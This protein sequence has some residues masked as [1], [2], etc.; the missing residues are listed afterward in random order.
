MSSIPKVIESV[1][2][3]DLCIG[4]GICVSKCPE[5]AL[6]MDWSQD[7]FWVPKLDGTCNNDELCVSVCPFNPN[8][9]SELRTENEIANVFQKNTVL[10]HAKIGKYNGIYAGFSS[11]FRLGSS[12]GGMGTYVMTEL[13]ERGI[14]QHI[15]AVGDSKVEDRHYEYSIINQKQ[16]I[17]SA[18]KTRYYPVNLSSVFS[19]IGELEGQVAIVGVACFIKAIRLAQA[20]NPQLIEKIPFLIGIIC[21]GIKSRFYTDYLSA[22]AGVPFGNCINPEFRIKDVNSTA[23]DYSF[24]CYSMHSE[25]VKKTIRMRAIGDMWGTGLFKANACDFCDDVTTELADISLGDA[26]LQPYIKDG[27]G[28]NVIVS[29]SS[30]ADEIILDG[31]DAKKLV[32]EE[33]SLDRFL[34]SQQGSFNH[35]HIG[36]PFRIKQHRKRGKI[37]PFKRFGATDSTTFDFRMIQLLRMYIRK[38]SLLVWRS[39]IDAVEFDK[40][41]KPILYLLRKLTIINHSKKALLQKLKKLIHK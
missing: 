31:I 8:P 21:G 32:L 27:K 22:K 18:S 25:S 10:S 40:K 23:N 14:V 15:I 34:A 38:Q 1:V 41:M 26:W 39:T 16:E 6:G 20:S 4:C 12:S 35:R 30:F 19:K 11:E 33:L 24:G 2:T 13:L 36:L 28:T 9:K 29:R 17:L 7:G 3:Q 37:I 5:K